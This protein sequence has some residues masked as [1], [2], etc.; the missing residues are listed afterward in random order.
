M[1]DGALIGSIAIGTHL[2]AMVVDLDQ[3][4][5]TSRRVRRG[6]WRTVWAVGTS[7]ALHVGGIGLAIALI[8]WA[9]LS[10][11]DPNTA[12]E[13]EIDSRVVEREDVP[14]ESTTRVLPDHLGVLL[15]PSISGPQS[16]NEARAPMV[17]PDEAFDWKAFAVTRFRRSFDVASD[18]TVDEQES[19]L[20]RLEW[21][22][23][24]TSNEERVGEMAASLS[25]WLGASSRKPPAGDEPA[26]DLADDPEFD[27]LT[28]QV[29]EVL[30]ETAADGSEAYVLV[31]ADAEGRLS[32]MPTDPE[33]GRQLKRVL[34]RIQGNPLLET[35]YR[36]V[37]MG[38]L[39]RMLAE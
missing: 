27:P 10:G 17:E 3:S 34:D 7:L 8:L 21:M 36:D 33:N 15:R 11:A 14:V 18:R 25:D 37:V 6:R 1:I 32:R 4:P 39:D 20:D 13:A 9:A 5:G 35:L 30:V 16:P 26:V 2:T 29:H 23:G 28:A 38:L 19:K 12:D 22:L 31:M 24:H